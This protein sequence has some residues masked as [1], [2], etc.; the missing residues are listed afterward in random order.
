MVMVQIAFPFV[1][2]SGIS[3]RIGRNICNNDE[4]VITFSK[5]REVLERIGFLHMSV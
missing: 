5:I 4:E 3:Q 2:G 1:V